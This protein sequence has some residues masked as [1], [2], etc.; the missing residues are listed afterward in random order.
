MFIKTASWFTKLPP[1]HFKVGISR[2]VPRGTP[3]GYRRYAALNPGPWFKSST[4]PEY[5]A[6][7][8]AQLAKLKPERVAADLVALAPGRTPVMLCYEN[9]VGI[10]SGSCWC[11]RHLVAQ[12][13]EDTLGIQVEEVG[14]PTL[15]RWARLRAAGVASPSYR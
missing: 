7:Y 2:G 13:L 9:P 1:D 6:L 12:W 4:V 14:H 15:D 3:A 8:G 10:Q 11:H 5:L